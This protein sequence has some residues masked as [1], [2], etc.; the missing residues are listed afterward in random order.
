M[1]D[2]S[3]DSSER[4]E[5]YYGLVREKVEAVRDTLNPYYHRYLRRKRA[6]KK[7]L[8]KKWRDKWSERFDWLVWEL[9]PF[10][11]GYG[12]AI[13]FVLNRLLGYEFTVFTALAYGLLWYF[14]KVEAVEVWNMLS[15]LVK[16][17]ARVD[18]K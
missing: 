12:V 3:E 1:V 14:V 10:V 15:P 6:F 4:F 17:R 8:R 5:P 9:A 7:N 2:D 11:V 16:V 18:N 13:N